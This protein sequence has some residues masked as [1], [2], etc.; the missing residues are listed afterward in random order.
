MPGIELTTAIA[1][2]ID[3][4]FDLS[5]SIDLHTVSTAAT[6]ERA[7]AGVTTGLIGL[8]DEVTWRARHFG[9]WQTL[10]VRIVAYDRP[11][12]F[13]D[14]MVKGAFTRMAHDH[15]FD[16][17]GEQTTVRDVFEFMSPLGPLGRIADVTFLGRYMRALLIERNAVIKSV[18]ESAEWTRFVGR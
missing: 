8:G 15:Y 3:R 7:I 5:R 10:T 9:I 6:G 13:R 16:A 11:R 2:P 4:V 12:H 18:A 17:A 14:V 1:A